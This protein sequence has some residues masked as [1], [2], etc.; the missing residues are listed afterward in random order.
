MNFWSIEGAWCR[1][2][3]LTLVG[4]E[5]GRESG[6]GL[7]TAANP[8]TAEM[9]GRDARSLL[10][11]LLGGAKMSFKHRAPISRAMSA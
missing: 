4:E 8:D 6:P 9:Q 11:S 3:H 1:R 10:G 2:P 7:A 5:E